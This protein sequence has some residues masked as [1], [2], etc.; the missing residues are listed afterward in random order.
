LADGNP[1][2]IHFAALYFLGRQ[3]QLLSGWACEH[4]VA[5][6]YVNDATLNGACKGGAFELCSRISHFCNFQKWMRS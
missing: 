4:F 2:N 1:A 3:N 5:T 6:V